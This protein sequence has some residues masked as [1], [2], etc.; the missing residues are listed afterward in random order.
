MIFCTV[1]PF[2]VI[3]HSV[4]GDKTKCRVE[5]K[6][7]GIQTG[8]DEAEAE[9]FVDEHFQQVISA[10]KKETVLKELTTSVEKKDTKEYT[11]TKEYWT[12][13]YVASG[14]SSQ[15]GN[16]EIW[17]NKQHFDH[18]TTY[19]LDKILTLTAVVSKRDLPYVKKLHKTNSYT[20]PREQRLRREKISKTFCILFPILALL[21]SGYFLWVSSYRSVLIG[22]WA[23]TKEFLYDC[24]KGEGTSFLEVIF[25]FVVGIVWQVLK[26]LFL[27][28]PFILA[29]VA[30]CYANGEQRKK[31]VILCILF[32]CIA[33]ALLYVQTAYIFVKY[34]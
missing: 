16:I 18:K 27:L 11:H 32:T 1:K 14:Y 23:E 5:C 25:I 34:I 20:K 15:G 9:A 26:L 13:E 29:I 6:V 33:V 24:W 28:L 10:F 30:M 4:D 12:S 19:F 2:E 21:I 8:E 17:Q 7:H 31:D 22:L 3:E